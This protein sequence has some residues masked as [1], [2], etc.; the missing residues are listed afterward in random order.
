MDYTLYIPTRGREGR[1]KTL[2]EL[3]PDLRKQVVLVADK[4]DQKTLCD[5]WQDQVKD[6]LSMNV[7]NLSQKRQRCIEYSPTDLVIF[8]DDNCDFHT[9]HPSDTG[10]ETKFPLKGLIKKNFTDQT[11][12]KHLQEAVDWLLEQLS[13]RYGMAGLSH[14]SDHRRFADRPFTPYED[15]TRL[16]GV[17]G[18]DLGK[19]RLMDPTP[20]FDDVVL[21]QDFYMALKF[22]T[23]GI[24]T[25]KTYEYAFGKP[26]GSNQK[27]GCSSY[28]T[29]ELMKEE[30]KKLRDMFPGIVTPYIKSSISWNDMPTK[31]WDVRINWKKAYVSKKNRRGFFA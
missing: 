27:G 12:Y 22:L 2:Q 9:V 4:G 15:N 28:R 19:L 25:I 5:E 31:V 10:V 14:R 7:A 18:I 24:P 3:S 1:Q 6:I 29:P 21:K 26:Y 23:A 13:G 20:R 8:M 17:W 16:F 11:R 30:A